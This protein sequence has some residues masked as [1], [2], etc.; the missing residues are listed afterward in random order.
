M[1][2]SKGALIAFVA[3][4]SIS[5]L[6]NAEAD[7]NEFQILLSPKPPAVEMVYASLTAYNSH[8]CEIGN[9][10]RGLTKSGASACNERGVATDYYNLPP[11]TQLYIGE[12][13]L[14]QAKRF[15]VVDDGCEACQKSAKIGH[16]L[17]DVRHLTKL[18]A[19]HFGRKDQIPVLVFERFAQAERF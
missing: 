10:K 9:Y 4:C 8:L 1:V 13:S 6:A 11:G 19:K 3:G 7:P 2:I 12:P 5:L 18:A 14:E 17:I 16:I 15:R